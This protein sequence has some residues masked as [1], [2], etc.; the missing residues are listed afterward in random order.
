MDL[1]GMDLSEASLS[2]ASLSKANL[3]KANLS[4]ANLSEADL[5][6]AD[7]SGTILSG[8]ILSGANLTL[9]RLIRTHLKDAV[10][11]NALVQDTQIHELCNLPH[12]PSRLRSRFTA[13]F[14]EFVGHEAANFFVLP[15]IV[16]VFLT[17]VLTDTELGC[18]HFHQG[19]I[20]AHR[21]AAEVYLVGHRHEA[22]GSVLRFQGPTYD[23]IYE[24]LPDLL[25]AFRTTEAIDWKKT[26]EAIPKDER[27]EAVATLVTAESRL[28]TGRWRIANRLADAFEGFADARVVKLVEGRKKGIAITV[29]ND[30]VLLE[31]LARAVLPSDSASA[32]L[33]IQGPS[34]H[35][36]GD[37]HMGDTF[38]IKGN[39]TGAALGRGASV[40]AEQIIANIS[41]SVE[42][43]ADTDL[44]AAVKAAL[45]A[46][47]AAKLPEPDQ[48]EA[49]QT[50]EKIQKEAE[51]TEADAARPGR[52][53]RWLDSLTA[54]CKPAAD[55][56]SA[57][58]AVVVALGS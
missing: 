42:H 48:V 8:A 38:N 52:V 11:E 54:I 15:A 23:A 49:A 6:E 50:V 21:V 40:T 12:P 20:H 47:T 33:V 16:E 26:L 22:G 14:A 58:K 41:Q 39:V 4:K 10:V 31:K 44:I 2:K 13:P 25:A 56:I 53:K 30:E 57:A 9:A 37:P 18:L 29:F 1:R 17:H 19:E 45:A 3:S 43:S 24:A 27:D 55:T 51:K 32:A 28:K 7:L 35:Y 34:T 46:I 36:H 5:S